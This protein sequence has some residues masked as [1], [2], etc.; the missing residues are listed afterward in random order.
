MKP[1]L[2]RTDEAAANNAFVGRPI[3]AA[4]YNHGQAN[5]LQT[6]GSADSVAVPISFVVRLCKKQLHNGA[7]IAE[8]AT[9]EKN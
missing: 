6:N 4:A 3:V 9:K 5:D 7:A 2:V 1:Y 8:T